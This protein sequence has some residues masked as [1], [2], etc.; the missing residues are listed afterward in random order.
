MKKQALLQ[1]SFPLCI[2]IAQLTG[3]TSRQLSEG[4][5]QRCLARTDFAGHNE[6]ARAAIGWLIA[7]EI[8]AANTSCCALEP[9]VSVLKKRTDKTVINT[10]LLQRI[11]LLEQGSDYETRSRMSKDDRCYRS[12]ADLYHDVLYAARS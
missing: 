12:L 8:K 7:Y 1:R 10:E 9:R 4:D 6:S 11:D 2:L 5:L 3:C